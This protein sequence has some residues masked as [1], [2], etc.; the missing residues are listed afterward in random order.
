M[1]EGPRSLAV[2]KQKRLPLGSKIDLRIAAIRDELDLPEHAEHEALNAALLGA[3]MY[4]PLARP[5]RRK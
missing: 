1:Y 4:L 3:M 2:A 5:G